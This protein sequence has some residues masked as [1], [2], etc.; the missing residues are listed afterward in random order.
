MTELGIL[1]N[2]QKLLKL[3]TKNE[4]PKSSKI[5]DK[6]CLQTS[7]KLN[8]DHGTVSSN[9]GFCLKN[10]PWDMCIVP[11]LPFLA[12]IWAGI[13]PLSGKWSIKM[14]RGLIIDVHLDKEAACRDTLYP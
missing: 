13:L 12:D 6:S 3:R 4:I 10:W 7:E 2:F 5:F 8:H 9:I 11:I 14:P 1:I